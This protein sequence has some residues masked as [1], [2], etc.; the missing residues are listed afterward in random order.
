MALSWSAKRKALYGGS[1]AVVLA[2]VLLWF[3]IG[4]VSKPASCFDGTQ[5]QGETGVDCGGPCS[6]ICPAD[7]RPPLVLWSRSFATGPGIYTAAAYIQNPNAAQGGASYRVPYAFRLY[8]ANN[9]LVVERD[10]VADLPPQQIIPIVET[11]ISTGNRA[12]ANAD[13]AF[14]SGSIVWTKMP[15]GAMPALRIEGQQLSQDGSTLTANLVNTSDTAA[16]NVAVAA[17]LFDANDNAQGASKSTIANIPAG[18]AQELDFT[19]TPGVPNIV[20]VVL[21]PLPE[22]PPPPSR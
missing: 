5:N 18:G 21:V 7:A 16:R 3:G 13:F 11:N 14:S 1:V 22:L 12:V 8:D 17:I 4:L 10:G 15:Q 9:V 19:W 2:A 6:R 20:R